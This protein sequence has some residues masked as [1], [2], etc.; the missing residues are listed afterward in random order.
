MAQL[1]QRTNSIQCRNNEIPGATQNRL[2]D[3]CLHRIV[4]YE[5]DRLCTMHLQ[6]QGEK[7]SHR[8][9]GHSLQKIKECK[10]EKSLSVKVR[11]HGERKSGSR[12]ESREPNHIAASTC[13]SVR[14]LWYQTSDAGIVAFSF[15]RQQ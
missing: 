1:L 14:M 15:L 2:P 9:I 3:C 5:K 7:V 8:A 10:T 12:N 4:I 6:L 11:S 13:F